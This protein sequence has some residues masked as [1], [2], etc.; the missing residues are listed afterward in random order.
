MGVRDQTV[1]EFLSAVAAAT[2]TPG[3]GSV[4]ALAGALSVALSRMVTGLAR[5]KKGY[6]DVQAELARI[7]ERAK[8]AQLRLERLIEEDARAY[9][10]VVTAMRM[11]RSTDEE[12]TA[13]VE[14]MQTAYKGATQVPLETME[15]CVEALEVAEAAAKKGNRGASTDVGVAIL[16]AEAALRGASLNCR[17]NLAAIR[18][19]TFRSAT[20]EKMSRLLARADAV[21]HEAMAIVSSRM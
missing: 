13:R 1:G 19:E 11:P 2:P 12:R 3:G 18:D 8:E 16:L 4:S 5:D 7:E 14:A 20:E 10:A 15:R 9:D 17:V 21:G 6:E